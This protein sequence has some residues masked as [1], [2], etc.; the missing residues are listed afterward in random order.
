MKAVNKNT[1]KR[2]KQQG[3]QGCSTRETFQQSDQNMESPFTF[4]A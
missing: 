2:N 3:E 4:S 1:E